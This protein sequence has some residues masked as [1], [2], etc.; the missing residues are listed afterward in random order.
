[1]KLAVIS[2]AS[3]EA[4]TPAI[5]HIV[6]A[7]IDTLVTQNDI[8][9]LTGG[10]SGIPGLIVEKANEA[11]I[12]TVAFSPDTDIHSHDARHDNLR[13]HHF[14][15]VRHHAGFTER[16]LAMLEEAD[17]VLV[18]NGRMGTLSEFTIAL[19]EGKQLAV[20]TGTG[21]IADHL[22]QILAMTGKDFT[23][24]PLFT[25]DVEAAVSHLLA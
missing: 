9:L 17:G 24:A 18:L 13:A 16:S 6:S 10:C 21:G 5:E 4:L 20:I 14:S 1:M 23:L 12:R 15:E 7:L 22:E 8:E 25:A 19:E 2:S 11:G 3:P